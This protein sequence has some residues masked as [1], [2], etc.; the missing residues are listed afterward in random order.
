MKTEKLMVKGFSLPVFE[1]FSVG[2]CSETPKKPRHGFGLFLASLKS[3]AERAGD[4][5]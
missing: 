1:F 5:T 4:G 3:A 2:F